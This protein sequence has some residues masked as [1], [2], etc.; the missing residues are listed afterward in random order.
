MLIYQ[1]TYKC[2]H[3]WSSIISGFQNIKTVITSWNE[4]KKAYS[5]INEFRKNKPYQN[6]FVVSWT[7]LVTKF[8]QNFKLFKVM[9][10]HTN[11][12]KSIIM[13]MAILEILPKE[14]E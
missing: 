5:Y 13:F 11:K 3:Q 12:S 6:L 8:V 4:R 10:K 14:L 2:D 9:V 1:G 7:F